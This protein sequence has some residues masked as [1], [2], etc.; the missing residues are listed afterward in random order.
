[1]GCSRS[2]ADAHN[3]KNHRYTP[4]DPSLTLRMTKETTLPWMTEKRLCSG[5]PK[6][7]TDKDTGKDTGKRT[8]KD[9]G[10][11][12]DKRTGKRTDKRTRKNTRK[13][14][15][16]ERGVRGQTEGK[17]CGVAGSGAKA[18]GPPEL[19]DLQKQMQERPHAIPP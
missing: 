6:R 8:D 10:K 14:T 11:N 13:R 16:Y 18:Y 5:R 19:P 17:G 2:F 15:V 7:N 1:M 3:D 12:T 9:T 4:P